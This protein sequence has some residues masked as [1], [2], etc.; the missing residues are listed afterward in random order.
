MPVD[1]YI[2]GIEHDFTYYIQILCRAINLNK[3]FE[4][5]EPF[6]GYLLKGWFVTRHI[7]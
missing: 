5:K 6:K 4:L 2:G 7:R 1:Q 3:K